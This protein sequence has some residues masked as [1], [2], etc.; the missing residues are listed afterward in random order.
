MKK[1]PRNHGIEIRYNNI[2]FQSDIYIYIYILY[3]YIYIYV[4]DV[5]NIKGGINENECLMWR[6]LIDQ[7]QN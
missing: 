2:Q 1:N 4:K 7:L 3:I 6:T 5:R